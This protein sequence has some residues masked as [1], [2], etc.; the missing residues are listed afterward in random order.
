[1]VASTEVKAGETAGLLSLG[2]VDAD[3]RLRE[4]S[5]PW[6]ATAAAHRDATYA[7]LQGADLDDW[8]PQDRAAG[9]FGAAIDELADGSVVVSHGTV[10]TLWLSRRIPALDPIAFWSELQMPDAHVFDR[11]TGELRSVRT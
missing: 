8:E 4:V 5:K 9:R 11:S 2:R 6:Y 7:Y 1:M 10:W 3:E